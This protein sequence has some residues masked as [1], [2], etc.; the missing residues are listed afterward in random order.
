VETLRGLG[1]LI[2]LRALGVW[3]R[4]AR[5]RPRRDSAHPPP[6][7]SPVRSREHARAGLFALHLDTGASVAVNA[8]RSFPLA[9]LAKLGLAVAVLRS[10]DRGEARLA[11]WRPVGPAQW[12][13][14]S[15]LLAQFIEARTL[16]LPAGTILTLAL[17]ES[18]NVAAD[19]L[20]EW[21]GGPGAVEAE[22][23]AVGYGHMAPSRSI[24]DFIAAVHG[25]DGSR[26]GPKEWWQASSARSRDDRVAA[27]KAFQEDGRD[28]VSPR[29]LVA[30]LRALL[31]EGILSPR[32]GAWL[33]DVLRRTRTGAARIPAAAPAGSRIAHKTGTIEGRYAADA[34]VVDLPDGSTILVSAHSWGDSATSDARIADL[35]SLAMRRLWV[36]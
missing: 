31:Q 4:A 26:F 22:L 8:D 13:P 9:S 34:G 2:F 36:G 17:T 30:F 32:S 1:I 29:Q 28:W 24:R 5:R 21:M 6:S 3:R 23:A 33:F 14:G 18:D 27:W 12:C 25:L 20:L 7:G 15:G 35:T 11:E 10:V 16:R 19:V